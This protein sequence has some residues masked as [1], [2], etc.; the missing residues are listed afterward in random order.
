[1]PMKYIDQFPDI[2]WHRLGDEIVAIKD[3]C[4]ATHVLNKTAAF[5]WERCNGT[6]RIE[7]ITHEL[8]ENF[9]VS[10]DV[11][12]T[13]VTET[14]KVLKQKGMVNFVSSKG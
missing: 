2:I 6:R 9:E 3:D 11:A 5:I 10:P 13:D 4:L 8:C 7:E 1:M 14:I 12:H